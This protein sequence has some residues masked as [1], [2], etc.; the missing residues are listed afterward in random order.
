MAKKNTSKKTITTATKKSKSKRKVKSNIP[1]FTI[2]KGFWK[3]NAVPAVI[4]F[5]LSFL[6]Y[7]QS[8]NYDFVL[9]DKIVY[10]QNQQV[11]KGFAGIKEILTTESMVGYFGEQQNLLQ[12]NRYRPLSIVT[13]AMEHEIFGNSSYKFEKN[14]ETRFNEIPELAP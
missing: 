7:I 1:D 6:L 13:F 4:L 8:Y 2:E 9:D 14:L 5:A 11:K 3:K 10:H 12:G